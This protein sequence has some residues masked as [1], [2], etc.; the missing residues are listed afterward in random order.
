MR[1]LKRGTE[2]LKASAPSSGTCEKGTQYHQATVSSSVTSEHSPK[3][4]I[5]PKTSDTEAEDVT[6]LGYSSIRRASTNPS[7]TK[8]PYSDPFLNRQHPYRR[9]NSPKTSTN[10]DAY[11]TYP[12]F[13]NGSY[14]ENSSICSHANQ[15]NYT[16]PISCRVDNADLMQNFKGNEI[17]SSQSIVVKPVINVFLNNC[18]SNNNETT[19]SHP[20]ERSQS[21]AKQ[22]WLWFLSLTLIKKCDNYIPFIILWPNV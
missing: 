8:R 1:Y 9:Q 7:R 18:I 14:T 5:T 22:S 15:N 3:I 11:L 2:S 4:P 20:S 12:N 16:S 17:S 10:D 6:D 21:Y 19:F 13:N